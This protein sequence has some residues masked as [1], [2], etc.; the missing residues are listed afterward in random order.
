MNAAVSL[1]VCFETSTTDTINMNLCTHILIVRVLE[2][3]K[4]Y[5]SSHKLRF[6]RRASTTNYTSILKSY[7]KQYSFHMYTEIPAEQ[8]LD[9][10]FYL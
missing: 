9:T 8:A 10:T 1:F 7:T 2:K 6:E 5:L 4:K 3:Y